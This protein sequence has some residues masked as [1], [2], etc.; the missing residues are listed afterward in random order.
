MFSDPPDIPGGSQLVHLHQALSL[1]DTIVSSPQV[2]APSPTSPARA[3]FDPAIGRNLVVVTPLRSI[4]LSNQAE[5]WRMLKEMLD[6]LVNVYSIA[7]R[8]TSLDWMV[9]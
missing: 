9:S 8:G 6:G 2:A 5:T 7:D 4:A 3:A 1:L